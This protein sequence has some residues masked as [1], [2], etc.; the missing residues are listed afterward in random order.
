M[1]RYV[2]TLAAG[3]VFFSACQKK[4][5]TQAKKPDSGPLSVQVRPVEVREITRVVD[6]VG[7]LFPYDETV[8]SSEVDGKV[9]SVNVDLGDAVKKGQILVKLSDEEQSYILAQDEAT[10]RSALERLGLKSDQDRLA[11]VRQASE[12]R[13]AQAD[14][15]DAQNRAGRAKSLF[16]QGLMPQA[17][18]DAAQIKL[19]SAQADYDQAVKAVRNLLQEVE[20]AKAT[21]ELQ[22]KK[23]RDTVI[24][25]PFDALVKERNVNAGAFLKANSPLLTLVRI[26]PIRL[27]IEIPERLA[28]WVRIGQ[29]ADVRLE[30]F[31]D[32]PFTGKIWRISPTVDATKRTFIVEALIDNPRRELKP[33]SY[34]RARIPTDRRDQ[35]KLVPAAAINYVFGSNKAYIV[36]DQTI[37]ARDVKLG[38]RFE[39]QVEIVEGVD[40]KDIL[41]VTK[42][43]QL[44]TGVKVKVDAPPTRAAE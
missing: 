23:L 41:A 5:E 4:P 43:N 31:A 14:L 32:R 6:S 30:A 18:F 19:K 9:V 12:V 17:D 42:L 44:D 7:T 25:A 28:P 40:P 39:S 38:D 11:D 3:L 29:I 35:V 33:G 13:R 16:D 27:K 34:A 15:S 20:R 1:N 37:E 10:L 26:D 22:R 21:V 24:A 8:L 36:K 2:L